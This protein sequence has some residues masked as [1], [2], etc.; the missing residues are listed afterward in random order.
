MKTERI[1]ADCGGYDIEWMRL[2]HKHKTEY[3]RGCACP[4]CA[5]EEY[6]DYEE[7]GPYDL[8]D[9]LDQALDK[10]FPAKPTSAAPD[11]SPT[12]SNSNNQ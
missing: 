4:Y 10:S 6:D 9:L 11:E 7:D 8:E 1:C 3:C 2:C 12:T 5:E